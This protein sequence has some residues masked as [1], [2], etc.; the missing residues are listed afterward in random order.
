MRARRMILLFYYSS[1]SASISLSFTAPLVDPS[2]SL[3]LSLQ[4]AH[5]VSHWSA[6]DCTS[7]VLPFRLKVPL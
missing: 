1:F 5:C 2:P 7:P 4:L 3:V 6:L